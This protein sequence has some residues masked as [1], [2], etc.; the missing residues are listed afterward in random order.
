M[1]QAPDLVA[2]CHP[3]AVHG[4]CLEVAGPVTPTKCS[5]GPRCARPTGPGWR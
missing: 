4:V 1:K 3:I 2:L 5:S